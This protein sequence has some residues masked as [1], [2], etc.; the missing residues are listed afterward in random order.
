MSAGERTLLGEAEA[1]VVERGTRYGSPSDTHART[2]RLWSAYLG[3]EISAEQVAWMNILQKISRT[4]SGEVRDTR[5]DVIG[6]VLNLET[7]DAAREAERYPRTE[8]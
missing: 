1:I 4:A 5:I 8:S 2:A 7:M 3:I 6:Y